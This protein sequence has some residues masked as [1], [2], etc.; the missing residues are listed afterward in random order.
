MNFFFEPKGIAVVGATPEPN[1]GGQCLVANL[2]LG[3]QGPIYPVNPKYDEIFG[4]K[5]YPRVSSIEGPLDLALIFVPA[6][7]VPQV[8]E[9]CIAKG[10]RGAIVE[11]GGFAEIGPEGKALQDR[12]LEI[13][14]R[15]NLR[16][17]GPNCMGLIDTTRQYVFS[18]I[19]SDA[20]QGVMNPGHVSLV[21][22]S[23]LLSGGFVTTLMGNKTLGLAKVCSIGNKSD[24]DE[25]ELL[26]YFLKDPATEVIA[27]YLES[28]VKGRLFFELAASSD[29][30]IVVLKGGKSSLGAEASISHTASLAGNYELIN[31]VLKQAGIHQAE[32][33]FE[34]VDIA[35]TLERGFYLQSPP[36]RK[37]RIAILSYSGAAGIVTADHMEKYGLTLACLSPHTQKR[38]EELSPAWMPI[39]NPVDYW[40]AMEKYGPVPT[41]KHAIETLH[42]D[43][44]VDGII[45]HLFAGFGIWFLNMKEIMVDLK[46]PRKPILF[47]LIGPEK[48]REPTR[49]DLEEEGWPTFSE[50]Q[51][52]VKVM[53]S[54]FERPGRGSRHPEISRLDFPNS[55]FFGEPAHHAAEPTP[56]ILDEFDSKKWLEA[57]GLRVVKEVVVN[58]LEE[59]LRAAHQMG[60]PVVLKARAEGQ[61][62]K[63]ETGLVKL[64]LMNADQVKSAYQGMMDL[65]S[66][67]QS[68]LVQ[69]MLKGD[70]ELITGIVRDPQ[71]GPTVM[72]GL[73]G[74]WAEVYKDVVFRMAP[75]KKEEIFEMVSDL[76]GHALLKGYRSLKPV[77]LESLADWLIKLGWLALNFEKI[78]EVDINPLL[79]VDGE[80]VAVD[81]TIILT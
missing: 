48:G 42:D 20:W 43:P 75:I 28:F 68:F 67:I 78:K 63:T 24:V 54:L 81:A 15:G 80:P 56:K 53:A 59:S 47:W 12:C 19:A 8:L 51:R 37:P 22:Q 57:L 72:L 74:V 34:M 60:Y 30:P 46:K 69:P 64:N 4:L 49:L 55:V 1:Q 32:D 50:I 44:E 31:G 35:R 73:G 62:H 58:N 52:T 33:F 27:F 38:L 17:W 79:I 66:K 71:F 25:S 6:Q 18:F 70:F 21:V 65:K 23:G 76:K 40:P 2:T 39:R 11:S 3:Y 16:I 26:E 41:Y 77:N 61:V 29:K 13:A 10:V 14:R 45:V 36:G 5:C 9:D 7:A